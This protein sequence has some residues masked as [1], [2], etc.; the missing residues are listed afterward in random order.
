[1]MNANQI[2][3]QIETALDLEGAEHVAPSVHAWFLHWFD[4]IFRA[5]YVRV[6]GEL[7]RI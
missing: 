4:P 3:Q 7:N 6:N 5:T 1:M 2:T